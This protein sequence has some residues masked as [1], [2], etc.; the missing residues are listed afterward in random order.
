MS[1]GLFGSFIR[2]PV[3]WELV[4]WDHSL[5]LA[6]A[7]IFLPGPCWHGSP[8]SLEPACLRIAAESRT[9]LRNVLTRN[10]LTLSVVLWLGLE[11]FSF[12]GFRTWTQKPGRKESSW[13]L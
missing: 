12:S 6:L 4:F 9:D 2:L 11:A 7:V 3:S 10:L 8:V 1:Q 13:Q 5:G